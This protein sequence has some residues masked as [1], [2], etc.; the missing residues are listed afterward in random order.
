MNSLNVIIINMKKNI[1]LFTLIFLV[2]CSSSGNIKKQSRNISEDSEDNNKK[3][4]NCITN[5][6]D[7]ITDIFFITQ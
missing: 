5:T 7:L 3:T 2:G 4:S 1:L 6:L